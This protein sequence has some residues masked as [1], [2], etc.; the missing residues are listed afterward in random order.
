[1]Y[2]S[3]LY[4]CWTSL[5]ITIVSEPSAKRFIKVKVKVKVND[6]A[7]AKANKHGKI[8][9]KVQKTVS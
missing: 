9:Q 4:L 8:A 5:K 6:I 2:I 1:M 7:M 3:I